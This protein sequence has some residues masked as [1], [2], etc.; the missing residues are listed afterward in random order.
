M[1]DDNLFGADPD[2]NKRKDGK[3]ADDAGLGNLPPLSDFDSGGGLD[4]DAELPP[5]GNFETRDSGMGGLPPLGE[6]PIE[7]P[8]PSGGNIRPAPPGFEGSASGI[9]SFGGRGTGFQDLA[10]DSDFSPETPDIGPGPDTSLDTPIFDSAFGP[11]DSSF[12]FTPATP[13]PAP[14]QAMETPVFGDQDF[15]GGGGAIGGYNAPMG[16]ASGTPVPDF[17]PDTGFGGGDAGFG[18]PPLGGPSGSM[19]QSTGGHSGSQKS[20]KA[21]GAKKGGVNTSVALV[22]IVITLLLGVYGSPYLND[23][24]KDTMGGLPAYYNPSAQKIADLE[25]DNATL[26]KKVQDLQKLPVSGEG[27]VEISPERV[28]EL[29]SEITSKTEQLNQVTGQLEGTNATLQEKQGQL[30][31]LEQ[32]ITEKNEEYA[33][34]QSVYEDLRNETSIIQARQRGL[35]S[36]VDRLT[37]LVGELEGA[38]KMRVATKEAL[39]HNIDRLLIQ[40]KESLALTPVKYDHAVRLAAAQDLR[41]K[42]A[43]TNW[44]TPELQEAYSTLYLRELEIARSNEYF[45]A[46]VNVTN[47]LGIQTAKWAECLMRGNWGVYYRTLD[48]KNVGVYENLGTSDTPRWGFREGLPTEAQ[49]AVESTVISSRVADYQFKVQQLAQRELA[50]KDGTEWQRNFEAL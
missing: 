26:T 10:A 28:I 33:N 24:L 41:D 5:L 35:V 43:Q 18:M 16:N 50:A 42:A 48:G 40:V 13:T 38:N 32:Q 25:T 19:G 34:A 3:G 37:G 6:I 45:F 7:T 36:E 14:T 4:P 20:V 31:G 8:N 21:I 46:K 29:Q 11:S 39:E 12:T 15:G 9:P 2:D 30:S 23:S 1:A 17:G 44:V 22:L 49:K 47:D 27:K